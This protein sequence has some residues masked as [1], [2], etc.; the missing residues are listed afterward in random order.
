M[1][2][3]P[4]DLSHF[5]SFLCTKRKGKEEVERIL[6]VTKK[7]GNRER[8]RKLSLWNR[9]VDDIS[10]I[11]YSISLFLFL[12]SVATN[13]ERGEPPGGH[14]RIT[15]V[16]HAGPPWNGSLMR[17]KSLI[18]LVETQLIHRSRD[19]LSSWP[20]FLTRQ[21]SHA[22][23][24]EGRTQAERTWFEEVSHG[25]CA[26]QTPKTWPLHQSSQPLVS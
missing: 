8:C 24:K 2:R 12:I 13:K 25:S 20:F 21:H 19:L 5:F 7:S 16:C 10:Q 1:T 15:F 9:S 22:W 17:N 3:P 4:R 11:P 18:L 6:L 26:R 23:K 14:E